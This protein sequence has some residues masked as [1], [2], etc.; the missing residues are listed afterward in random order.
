MAA[1][2]TIALASL[3]V[4]AVG[5]GVAVY[6]QQQ[7][8]DA[9]E[10]TG[11]YNA[12]I[13]RQQATQEGQVAA[14]NARRKAAENARIIGAQRAA[15]AQSGLAMEGTPLAVL[16]ETNDMLE[17][18]LMDLGYDASQRSRSLLAGAS[19]SAWQG[20]A[21]AAAGRMASYGTAIGGIASAGMGYAEAG[22]YLAPKTP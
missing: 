22:G 9:A 12:K 16:G 13:Q 1:A 20:S 15:L 10:A 8:A 6:G 7:A 21:G 11:K 3:A 18:E 2:T 17:L 4:A 14:E 19:M 5:T